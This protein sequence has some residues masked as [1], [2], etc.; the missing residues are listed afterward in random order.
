VPNLLPRLLLGLATAG[1]ATGC[2]MLPG[3]PTPPLPKGIQVVTPPD[4]MRVEVSNGTTIPVLLTVNGQPGHP[5]PAGGRADLG[6]ADLGPLPWTAQVRTASGRVLVALVVRAG[7]VWTQE[8]SDG[9][10]EA[11]SVGGRVDLSCGRIDIWSGVPM[12][13]PAPGS[14]APGDCDP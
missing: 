11:K 7:E 3:L 8:N 6:L 1:A 14:G 4:R 9:S 10:G 2:S 12:H 13:G 5:V